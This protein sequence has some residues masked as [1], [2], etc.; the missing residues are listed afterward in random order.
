MH[1]HWRE[2]AKSEP[3]HRTLSCDVWQLTSLDLTCNKLGAEGAKAIAGA[4]SSGMAVLK[5]IVLSTN[6][7]EDEGAVAIGESLMS[8]WTL[9][10]LDL[11]GCSIGVMGGKALGAG[12]QDGSALLTS[13]DVGFNALDE[14]AALSIVRA[15]RKH[16]KMTILG[17]GKCK[18][19]PTGAQEIADYVLC[20]SML[21]SLN[22]AYNRFGPEG[23]QA[24]AGALSGGVAVLNSIDLYGNEIGATGAIAMANAMASG[25]EVRQD[26]VLTSLNLEHYYLDVEQL[27]LM[28]IALEPIREAPAPAP[29]PE[30]PSEPQEPPRASRWTRLLS[31]TVQAGVLE[32]TPPRA[33]SPSRWTRLLSSALDATPSQASSTSR[34]SRVVQGA[35][36]PRDSSPNRWQ[37]RVHSAEP[38]PPR[39]VSPGSRWGGVQ[40]MVKSAERPSRRTRTSLTL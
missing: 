20:T 7:I 36:P 39:A 11:A 34:L 26:V 31:S 17:L 22:V 25:R 24:I 35:T 38:A 28:E 6:D 10:E 12:L 19:G 15:A 14:E 29:E 33:S 5:K 16:D 21:T 3:P 37:R 23:A 40:K 30:P 18:I 2:H 27:K 1:A 32:A 13:L 4:L 9:E 8:N